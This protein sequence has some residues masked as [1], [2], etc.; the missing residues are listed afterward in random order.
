MLVLP[1]NSMDMLIVNKS[2]PTPRTRHFPV[3]CTR[4]RPD[5]QIL[6]VTEEVLDGLLVPPRR[7]SPKYFYDDHGSMLFDRICRTEEYYL[8]RTEE[9]LLA[10]HSQ[11]IIK[12]TMPDQILEL[13]SGVSHKIRLL[14][15]AC[16]EFSHTCEYAPFDVCEEVVEQATE[17]LAA[18][19]HWLEI[20][21]LIG[22]YHAGLANLP[23]A[24]GTR[25]IAFLGST[26]GNFTA[27]QCSEFIMDVKR[28]L[29]PGDYFLLGADRIKDPVVLNAAY[30][31]ADGL[32]AEFNL[33]ILRVLNRELNADFDLNNFSHDACFNEELGQMEMYLVSTTEQEVRLGGNGVKFSLAAGERILTEISR[34][35]HAR[36]LESMLEE[37]NFSIIRHF[38]PE[39]RYYS[40][41]LGKAE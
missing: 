22:D 29:Q 12:E 4:I 16:S 10:Q 26:I 36:E 40:L 39:N 32:T 31:D 34:K 19:Y 3:P 27:Q 5:R 33:N 2:Q 30:N 18:D 37:H 20:K 1:G 28:C 21:P 8:T 41:L 25:L 17:Q 15:N 14:F 24:A 9:A 23:G 13:G 38:Q 7:L 11:D 6:A 35:F